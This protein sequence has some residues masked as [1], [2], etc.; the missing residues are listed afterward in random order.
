MELTEKMTAF[1][2]TLANDRQDFSKRPSLAQNSLGCCATHDQF[3]KDQAIL[4]G[5]GRWK[6]AGRTG[7][8]GVRP[9]YMQAIGDNRLR[10]EITPAKRIGKIASQA[11]ASVE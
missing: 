5:G 7:M 8:S 4:L 6:D 1:M 3:L 11:P 2:S 9:R 10:G